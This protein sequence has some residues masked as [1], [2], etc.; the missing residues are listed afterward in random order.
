MQ[1]LYQFILLGY[2]CWTTDYHDGGLKQKCGHIYEYDNSRHRSLQSC[3]DRAEY[4]GTGFMLNRKK[5]GSYVT[6]MT[7]NCIPSEAKEGQAADQ[8]PFY[9]P[10]TTHQ[11]VW[12]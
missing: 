5:N 9:H 7:I 8:V 12:Q 10:L 2:L 11:L 1:P 6:E 4:L 3:V